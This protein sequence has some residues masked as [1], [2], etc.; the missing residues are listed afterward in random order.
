MQNIKLNEWKLKASQILMFFF[1]KQYYYA[2]SFFAAT[3][4]PV[5]NLMALH[6]NTP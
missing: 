2:E 1:L 5:K 4:V 3:A 6:A